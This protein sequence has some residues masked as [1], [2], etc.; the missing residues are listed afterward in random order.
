MH[1]ETCASVSLTMVNE[2]TDGIVANLVAQV[3]LHA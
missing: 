1:P 3:K 2:Q